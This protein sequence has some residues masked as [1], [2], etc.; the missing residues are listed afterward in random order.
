MV[1]VAVSVAGIAGSGVAE[2]AAG[3]VIAGGVSAQAANKNDN[4]AHK[5]TIIGFTTISSFR[6]FSIILPLRRPGER[7]CSTSGSSCYN[8][9]CM[10]VSL[11]VTRAHP[12]ASLFQA[13]PGWRLDLFSLGIGLLLGLVVLILLFRLRPRAR[14]LR[15]QSMSRVQETQAWVR[16]GV[17]KRFQA[18]T[19]SY[20]RDYHLGAPW[21][22]LGKV[23]VKP[24]PLAERPAVEVGD[25]SP[26]ATAN[27]NHLW[28]EAAAA[29][30]TLPPPAMSVRRLLL[31]GRRVILSAPAGAGKTTLLAYCAHLCANASD[32]GPYTFLLPLM[33]VLVHL[34]ELTRKS[35]DTGATDEDPAILLIQALQARAG[36]L[37]APGID[38]LLRQKLATGHVL[39]LLD[40]WDELSAEGQK[41]VATWLQQL[42]EQ[43]P[44]IQAIVAT[45]PGGFAPL[46]ALRFTVSGLAPWRARQAQTA[47]EQWARA[48]ERAA[49][50][51]L[52]H[53]WQP[54]QSALATTLHLWQWHNRREAGPDQLSAL[55]EVAL[56][57]FL[58]SAT[59]GREAASKDSPVEQETG[60][61]K[62]VPDSARLPAAARTLWQ[63]LAFRLLLEERLSLPQAAVNE[64]VEAVLAA[65][66]ADGLRAALRETVP[67][68]ALF[69]QWP[70]KRIS[71]LSPLW[72]DFLAAAH[73]AQAEEGWDLIQA[74]L[75]DGT[76]ESTIRF[77][78]ARAGAGHL[79]PRL[80]DGKRADPWQDDLFR[81]ARWLSETEGQAEWRRQT[82]IRLGQLTIKPDVPGVVRQRAVAHIARTGEHGVISLIRQLLQRAEP[83]IRRAAIM[84]LACFDPELSVPTLERM[85]K[86]Q[87][88]GVRVT[89]VHAL[90]WQSS[91]VGEQPLLMALISRDE[92]LQTASAQTL[93]LNGGEGWEIL[94]EAAT[95]E[96]VA[97][98]RAAT[99]G[100]AL[101]DEYWA[102]QLLAKMEREEH[103]W[104]VKGAATV[105]LEAVA[106]RNR[107]QPWEVVEAGDLVWLIEWAATREEAVPGSNAALPTLCRVLAEEERAE[108]RLAAARSLVRVYLPPVER[109]AAREALRAAATSDPEWQVRQA[110]YASLAELDRG[111]TK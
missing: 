31:N 76:W 27:L 84:G 96:D 92:A 5:A 21:A 42:L 20:V 107:Q 89:A 101:L 6:I 18:E 49:P 74:H 37:T 22:T 77:Y 28:P 90:G 14:Q 81:A 3:T 51:R 60:D 46:Q 54:G 111:E 65:G 38:T 103:E 61:V 102:V 55:L 15:E 72:R 57:R 40:G 94:H 7:K 87:D 34:A 44:E 16:A 25:H 48:F 106:E 95:D 110:A 52:E 78:V 109:V 75:D 26:E 45:G 86:D 10:G 64:E 70:D 80:L 23:F 13:T 30:A 104:A 41:P 73:L 43:Y 98:R 39:L 97:V 67:G 66:S 105:A 32:S 53:Y 11:A 50:P 29:V 36:S 82:L 100:L 33:P 83:E 12:A 58:L 68:S 24:R 62:T 1:A 91:Q 79:A 8:H 71:F 35:N 59:A 85:L 4:I 9:L 2:A 99:R 108:F 69:R 63:R 93:A 17:E 19:A 47:G 56:E 88:V